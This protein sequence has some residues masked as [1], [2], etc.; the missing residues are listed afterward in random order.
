MATDLQITF[1]SPDP[2]RIAAFWAAALGYVV[3]PP[4]PGFDS[5]EAWLR[6]MGVPEERFNSAS[7]V[8]DPDGN[9]PRIFI[10]QVPEPKIA[11]NRVHLDLKVGGGPGT[12][13]DQRKAAIDAEA[14][15]LV[16]LGAT[17]VRPV[18][19]MGQYCVVMQDPDGNEFCVD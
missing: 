18:E 7:A 6:Q 13:M 10:Q 5:W 3:Q 8:I 9:G 15:R 1:D 17:L 12:P 16:G 2:A 4:P 11:K 14:D 19:E